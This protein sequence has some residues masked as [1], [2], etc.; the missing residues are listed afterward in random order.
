MGIF[1]ESEYDKYQKKVDIFEEKVEQ[2]SQ[3][4]EQF[5]DDVNFHNKKVINTSID[6][7]LLLKPF[8]G[9]IKSVIECT[10]GK[11]FITGEEYSMEERLEKCSDT[12]I[13][14]AMPVIGKV[15]SIK[16]IGLDYYHNYQSKK[17]LKEREQ[18]LNIT[19]KNLLEEYKQL[20]EERKKFE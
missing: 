7:F 13:G 15:L 19:E 12:S 6:T 8:F 4:I 5:E 16:N 3:D 9:T 17:N 1:G 11:N 14:E 10:F 2:Y 18:N 20:L